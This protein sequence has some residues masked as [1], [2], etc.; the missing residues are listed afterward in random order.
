[1][2]EVKLMVLYPVPTDVQQFENDYREHLS[3][4]HRKMNIPDDARPYTVTKF[5]PVP[6]RQAPY[7]QMF[8]MAFPS[9]EAL[10][11]AMSTPEMQEVAGDAARI[12]TGGDLVILV[13]SD[14]D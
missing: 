9:A 2:E 7:Y 13:G 3:F 12:S 8:S 11:Q 4:F 10:Q 1:M 6:G 14:T 5:R